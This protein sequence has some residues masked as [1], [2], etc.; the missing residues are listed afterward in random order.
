VRRPS[1]RLHAGE[2]IANRLKASFRVIMGVLVVPAIISIAIMVNTAVRYNAILSRMGQAADLKPTISSRIPDEVWSVVS[3]RKAFEDGEFFRMIGRVN[4]SLD[5]MLESGSGQN[6]LELLAARRAMDTLSG[7]VEDIGAKM[8]VKAPVVESE[9]LLA[10][11]R[12]VSGLIEDVLE[13]Y[14]SVEIEAAMRAS[15]TLI[16][17]ISISLLLEFAL[18]LLAL[19]F[20]MRAQKSLSRSIQAPIM[21]LEHF[22]G[23]LA[24]GDLRARVPKTPVEELSNLTDSFNVMADKL[25]ALVEQNRLEQ[26]NLKKSELRTLQA[27]VAPH[28]L[29]NTLD[30]IVWLAEA[31]ST[32]EVIH[33]TQ[34][35]SDF[36]RIS[37]SQGR[38]WIPVSEEI[39]HLRGYLTIQKTRYRDILDYE[40][41][42]PDD[43]L[44][45]QILKLL[46]QPLVENAIYHGIKFRR[47][48][49]R[50]RIAARR[51]GGLLH[52]AVEDNGPGMR[53]ERLVE[54]I[55]GLSAEDSASVG[56][57]L[58]NVD[59]RIRLYYGL[60]RGL[61]IHSSPDG[62]RVEFTVPV[63][64]ADDV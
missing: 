13:K 32:N 49:G 17:I 33:V 35:L 11:I 24:A 57:G 19:W 9:A 1:Y 61:S 59:R 20:S 25:E 28:F 12:G 54:V 8:A 30:A 51:K 22:A 23:I 15:D 2:S 3:G 55:A 64:R 41:D 34:A 29:Y 46:L 63:R 27:Q 7:Y 62:T 53:E 39:K 16:G 43:A 40:I 42:V 45:G 52:F 37:L 58:S 18:L 6:R 60:S 10:E 14:I 21:R 44:E 48:G 56:Y 36:F 38:D 47:R 5:S 31:G 50:V 26:E 4:R